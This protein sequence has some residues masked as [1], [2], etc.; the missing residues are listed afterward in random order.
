MSDRAGSDLQLEIKAASVE[1]KPVLENLLELYCYDFSEVISLE[2]GPDGRF[3]FRDLDLYWSEPQRFPFLLYRGGGLAGFALVRQI[4]QNGG[5]AARWEV[6]E[7]F[8]MRGFRRH[9]VGT[10]AAHEV[11][12]RFP[13]KWQV[14]VME[15]NRPAYLFWMRAVHAFAGNGFRLTRT[16]A[17]GKQW[18][19]FT[20]DSPDHG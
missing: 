12:A 6:A 16:T 5:D 2:I 20:F 4:P 18:S 14:R 9:G 19:V 7:F 8:V 3:G 13:G 1:M 15:A 11:F 17:Q 10:Q